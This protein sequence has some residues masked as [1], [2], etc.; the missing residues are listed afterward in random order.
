MKSEIK[1]L[2]DLSQCKHLMKTDR[3]AIQWALEQLGEV[4]VTSVEIIPADSI[5]AL[6]LKNGEHHVTSNDAIEYA[7][8]YPKIDIAQELKSMYMWIEANPQNR[9]TKSGI[10]R[11][12]NSWLSRA[13]EKGGSNLGNVKLSPSE[14][15]RQRHKN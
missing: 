3:D 6:K 4:K 14:R 13:N 5:I 1:R 9:K 11:F 7:S 2:T 15:F 12:I 8:A 10:N